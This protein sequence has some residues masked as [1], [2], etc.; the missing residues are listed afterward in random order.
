MGWQAWVLWYP[1]FC[2]WGGILW[3]GAL[4]WLIVYGGK[5]GKK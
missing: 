1:V 4:V 3:L 5:G 2:V